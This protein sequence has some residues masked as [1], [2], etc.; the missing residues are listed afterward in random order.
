MWQARVRF[1]ME[2]VL[3]SGGF[4]ELWPEA[5][6]ILDVP[7]PLSSSHLTH[8]GDTSFIAVSATSSADL[9]ATQREVEEDNKKFEQGLNGTVKAP[10]GERCVCGWAQGVHGC[11]HALRPVGTL[12]R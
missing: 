6:N 3:Y 12:R 4:R 1:C 9:L 11:G 7:P 2:S 5:L 8:V 10:E